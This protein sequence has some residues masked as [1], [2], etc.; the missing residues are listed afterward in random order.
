MMLCNV[1]LPWAA[2][3]QAPPS[4]VD[5]TSQGSPAAST[6]GG[7]LGAGAAQGVG[8]G[9]ALGWCLAG[10]AE[11]SPASSRGFVAPS[12]TSWVRTSTDS[13]LGHP[14]AA[15]SGGGGTSPAPSAAAVSAAGG[16]N[17]PSDAVSV[18]SVSS[19]GSSFVL[20]HRRW[21]ALDLNQPS[22]P[23]S[24]ESP[25]AS[26]AARSLQRLPVRR[27]RPPS[28]AGSWRSNRTSAAM[29]GY[30][31][32]PDSA[33]YFPGRTLPGGYVP[34]LA[35]P[36]RVC[37]LRPMQVVLAGPQGDIRGTCL[38]RNYAAHLAIAHSN[39][40][41]G[42][43]RGGPHAQASSAE[44]CA[45]CLEPFRAGDRVQ[46]MLSCRHFFHEACVREFVRALSPAGSSA[47]QYWPVDHSVRCPI[48][49]GPFADVREPVPEELA[50]PAADGDGAAAEG[51]LL[52]EFN[53]DWLRDE[54]AHDGVL[55]RMGSSSTCMEE[56]PP[57]LEL[58]N[59]QML[60]LCH[61]WPKGYYRRSSTS[62]HMEN[63]QGSS[64]PT[65]QQSVRITIHRASSLPLG[66][67]LPPILQP[68]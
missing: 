54:D 21:G 23:S 17:S 18:V 41:L 27:P 3:H 24:P 53:T 25:A 57:S 7:I 66:T 62:P 36:P 51:P 6:A 63:L 55:H 28:E 47:L 4:P 43:L 11:V 50:E 59:G 68:L 31:W 8:G 44:V 40:A 9:G 32:N 64:S 39:A 15:G 5:A 22:S 34:S 16:S 67:V 45:F 13:A 2:V 37:V 60:P 35:P 49:R 46:P 10:A 12:R 56:D 1:R 48:C 61:V 30:F 52:V 14:A 19:A 58:G 65:Q 33:N 38:P 42:D 20:G 29:V 26:E